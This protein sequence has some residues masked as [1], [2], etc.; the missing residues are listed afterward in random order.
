MDHAEVRERLEATLLGPDKPTL[1]TGPARAEEAAAV[2]E[3]LAACEPCRRELEA[4]QLTADLL[5]TDLPEDIRPGEGARERVLGAVRVT[6]V[7]RRPPERVPAEVAQPPPR[8]PRAS[9]TPLR[10]SLTPL[11]AALAVV[12]V[13][14]ILGAGFAAG[15]L[16]TSP[17]EGTEA[18]LARALQ[19]AAE[20]LA[21]PAQQR[22][23]L[24]D[25]SG[26][27][28]GTVLFAPASGRVV[29]VTDELPG[30]SGDSYRCLVERD[31]Q[32]FDVGPMHNEEGIGYWAGRLSG[33]PQAGREG[34]RFLVSPAHSP[35]T[36]V[37]SGTFERRS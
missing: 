33:V 13:G 32:R 23:T 11:R 36:P 29:V 31:G 3:H 8:R 26:E 25:G 10:A 24:R 7:P 12:A 28:A 19:V 22:V 37:L 18:R 17:A 35:G 20:I 9:L 1:G 27:V 16:T 21:E 2:R 4:L 34:D 30:G 15:R 6:G 14:L 5:A